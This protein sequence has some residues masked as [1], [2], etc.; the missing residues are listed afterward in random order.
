[1]KLDQLLLN[2]ALA[3]RNAE[4]AARMQDRE[5]YFDLVGHYAR[6]IA[7]L[8]RAQGLPAAAWLHEDHPKDTL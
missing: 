7:D 3:T 8:R 4:Q 5:T 2:H 6:K 1:M